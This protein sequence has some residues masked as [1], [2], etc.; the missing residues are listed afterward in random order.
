MKPGG[1]IYIKA[2]SP[3]RMQKLECN[4]SVMGGA[5]KVKPMVVPKLVEGR[6]RG[7]GGGAIV[8]LWLWEKGRRGGG[9]L[10]PRRWRGKT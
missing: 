10:V 2:D 9:G 6:G 8:V 7:G 4:G 3:Q 1:V 5:G